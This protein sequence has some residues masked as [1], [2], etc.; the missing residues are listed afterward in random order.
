METT[1][2]FEKK[3]SITPKELNRVKTEPIDDILLQKAVQMIE[4]KCSE[5][6]FVLPGSVSLLSRSVGYFEAARFTGDS[7]YYVKLQA[8]VLYPV[9]GVRLYGEVIRKNKMGLYV[10]YNNAIH[11]QIPR[12]LHIGDEEFDKVEIGQYVLVELKRSKFAINDA[13]ILSS[14]KYI[15]KN[16]DQGEKESEKPEKSVKE[17]SKYD[18]DADTE[19]SDV[20]K[21]EEPVVEEPVKP[22]AVSFKNALK[23]RAE[24]KAAKAAQAAEEAKA[25][26]A[27][28][29]AAELAEP[30]AEPLAESVEPLAELAEPL[31]ELAE[32]LA[33][34][35]EEVDEKEEKPATL[36]VNTS[37]PANMQ[38]IAPNS[39]IRAKP[40]KPVGAPDS[41][42]L[43][44]NKSRAQQ[45]KD[46]AALALQ[47]AQ[48]GGKVKTRGRKIKAAV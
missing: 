43:P 45:E 15:S 19:P 28:L 25:A 11:I 4:N 21:V 6:G 26:Q 39:P 42:E 27:E 38:Q 1:V 8:K 18:I 35:V 34:P 33:E 44:K 23:K 37:N 24:A 22:K 48:D 14:G 31:A 7:N 30:L 2:F 47:L 32:P 41:P 29:E 13:F 16:K 40:A 12:D 20:E 17:E 3:V 46:D 10:N 9:D 5:Q 36:R